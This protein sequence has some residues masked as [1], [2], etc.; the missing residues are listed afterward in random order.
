MRCPTGAWL[1]HVVLICVGK[2]LLDI[3]PGMTQELS[4]TILLQGYLAVSDAEI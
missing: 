1:I 2:V 4:W 3:V